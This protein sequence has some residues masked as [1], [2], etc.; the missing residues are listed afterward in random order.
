MSLLCSMNLELSCTLKIITYLILFCLH[1]SSILLFVS[2][3]HFPFFVFAL[4]GAGMAGAGSG[5]G[6]QM[7]AA[8]AESNY[9]FP[10]GTSL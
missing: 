7:S 2:F 4:L 8:L 10:S 3:S 5:L 1:L 6:S 9:A